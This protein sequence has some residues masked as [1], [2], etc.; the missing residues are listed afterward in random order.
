MGGA[1]DGGGGGER[2]LDIKSNGPAHRI[3]LRS[4]HYSVTLPYVKMKI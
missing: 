4:N 2:G 3:V 1:E